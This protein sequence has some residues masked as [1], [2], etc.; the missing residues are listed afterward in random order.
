[1]HFEGVESGMEMGERT[2]F[3]LPDWSLNEG[4]VSMHMVAGP[5]HFA[6]MNKVLWELRNQNVFTDLL[7]VCQVLFFTQ[8]LLPSCGL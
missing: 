2:E 1:M 7:L 3:V 5:Q 6:D 4:E 8:R